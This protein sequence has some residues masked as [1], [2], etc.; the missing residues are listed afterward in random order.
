MKNQASRAMEKGFT[1]QFTI[2]VIPTP[3]HQVLTWPRARRSILM[4]MGMTISQMSTATGRL[5]RATSRAPKAWKAA[6]NRWPSP[7]PATM[8]SSTHRVR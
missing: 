4:S 1:S 6:G 7:M 8:Q 2:S 5:M 3:R